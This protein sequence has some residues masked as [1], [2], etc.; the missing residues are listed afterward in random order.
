MP[1]AAVVL[2]AFLACAAAAQ[3]LTAR[4]IYSVARDDVLPGSRWLRRVD[5]RSSPSVATAVTALVAC[6]GLLLGLT[7]GAVASLI[8]FGT[9]AIYVAFLLVALAALVARLRGTWVPAGRVR[10]GRAGGL[11][12]ALAVS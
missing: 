6:L 9:A 10:L 3:S 2:A 12:D 11:A 4:A 7:S 5:R 8:A 1:F